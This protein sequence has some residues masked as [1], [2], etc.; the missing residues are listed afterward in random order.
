M[1]ELR[2]A[3]SL[4]EL[5]MVLAIM[6]IT[7]SVILPLIGDNDASQ[8]RAAAELL[9]ADIEDVQ[10]RSLA[11]PNA[12]TCLRVAS[13][14]SGWHIALASSPNEPL[15]DIQGQPMLRQFGFGVLAGSPEV[16]LSSNELPEV[17]LQF[18]DQGAPESLPGSIDFLLGT[19]EG[20]SIL[21]VAVSAST[22]RV[23]I[24]RN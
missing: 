12:Q 22:G 3:F 19:R 7:S 16:T 2:R 4:A 8:L 14:G 21:R 11:E 23:T 6:A 24:N 10:G 20:E 17:G 18:D 1:R 9:A 15:P 13:D 5:L